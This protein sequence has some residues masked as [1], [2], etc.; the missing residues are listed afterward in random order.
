MYH[1]LILKSLIIGLIMALP[2]GPVGMLS[3]RR[4]LAYGCR[5]GLASGVASSLADVPYIALARLGVT[6]F[7]RQLLAQRHWFSALGFVIVVC[8]GIKLLTA[9]SANMKA[10]VPGDCRKMFASAFLLTVSN[11]TILLSSAALFAAAGLPVTSGCGPIFACVSASLV[12]SIV[13]WAAIA[14]VLDRPRS[15]LTE[16]ALVR[17]TKFAGFAII[18]LAGVGLIAS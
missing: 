4:A 6:G 15:A 5:A 16:T 7:S 12:G 14:L 8:I 10:G 13:L 17:L 3:V 11:P 18:A 1:E 9:R 2:T